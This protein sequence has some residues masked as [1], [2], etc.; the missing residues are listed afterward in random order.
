MCTICRSCASDFGLDEVT[1]TGPTYCAQLKNGK[2]DQFE[3]RPEVI[4]IPNSTLQNLTGGSP[5]NN[6]REI[7]ELLNGKNGYFRDIVILNA[8]ST[9]VATGNAI[10]F[11]DAKQKVENS[12]NEGKALKKMSHLI[13]VSNK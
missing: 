2:I 11:E 13:E 7:I 4:N 6:A 12:L 1:S 10:N 8:S 9:L 3:I 5:E